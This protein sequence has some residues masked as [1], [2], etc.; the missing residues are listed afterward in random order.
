MGRRGRDTLVVVE[1]Q[2]TPEGILWPLVAAELGLATVFLTNDLQRYA[3]V[4]R[5]GAVFGRD[6]VS[7]M[8]A[9]TNSTASIV[10][11]MRGVSETRRVRGIFTQC[12]Y[13]LPLVAEVAREL[14]LPGLNPRAAAL[15][16]NK[17]LTREACR[18]AGVPSPD[19]LNA[20]SAEEAV[21]FAEKVGFPCVVKPMTESA[22]TDVAL[23]RDAGEVAR[24]F[25]RISGQPLDRRGQR[26]PPGALVEEYCA[27]H[28]VSVETFTVD[29]QV[30]VLGVVDKAVSPHPYFA[31]VGQVFPSVLPERVTGE[32]A[33]TAVAAL[34]AVGHDFGAAHTEVRMTERGPRLIEINARLAGEDI[35]ELVDA[36]LGLATRRQVLAM[37]VGE[38]PDLTV[39]ARRGAATRK[40]TFPASGTIRRVDGLDAA[41][42]SPG[43]VEVLLAVGEGDR[44]DALVSNHESYGQVRAEASEPGEA[45]RLAEAALNQISFVVDRAEDR[46]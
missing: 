14:G 20:T 23:G 22:S 44:V 4:P 28:E 27:G 5:F 7:V 13:N 6:D 3:K 33:A 8:T 32:L 43:V 16:R 19:F 26:R 24:L 46:D 45:Q 21:A 42:R 17:L 1:A 41:R 10:E 9:D 40:I 36:S 29:G 15:A 35:P 12:D 11:M 38:R 37:H 25:E 30:T 2:L 39:T 31:E 34:R 18:E